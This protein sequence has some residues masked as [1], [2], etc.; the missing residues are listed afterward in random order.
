MAIDKLKKE[1]ISL[2]E[3]AAIQRVRLE[4][5]RTEFSMQTNVTAKVE[6]AVDAKK[7]ELVKALFKREDI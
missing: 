4:D 6:R 2:R 3:S 1:Y 7:T 5:M